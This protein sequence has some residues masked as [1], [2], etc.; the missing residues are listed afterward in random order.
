MG[1]DLGSLSTLANIAKDPMGA[2][3]NALT[4]AVKGS[5][6]GL[7]DL[8]NPAKSRLAGAGLLG[9]AKG[10]DSKDSKAV[11]VNWLKSGT[12]NNK[13]LTDWRVKLSCNADDVLYNAIGNDLMKP[14]LNT[15]GLIFPITPVIQTTHTAKYSAQSLTHSN[16]AMQF[17]EGSEVGQIQIS[18]DFPVQN[19]DEGQYLLAAIYYLKGAT[20]MF[21]GDDKLAG[22]PPPLL[23]LSGYGSHYFPSVPCVL[24]SFSHTMPDDKDYIEVPTIGDTSKVTR[25][26]TLSTI[27]IVVQ[28]LYSRKAMSTFTTKDFASGKL[29]TGKGG[30]I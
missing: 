26:P 5:I 28:P 16:Y 13:G 9:G 20:K 15:N 25:L 23:T 22:S 24:I 8:L 12:Q 27:Q 30:F 6:G 11:P 2:A 1:F 29:L 21:W 7:G 4:S 14:I 19:I 17:Y 3:T 10:K 18:G